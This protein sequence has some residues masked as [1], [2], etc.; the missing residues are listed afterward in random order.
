MP[1]VQKPVA[2]VLLALGAAAA[3]VT[4]RRRK[5][6]QREPEWQPSPAA[7]QPPVPSPTTARIARAR[8]AVPGPEVR[9]EESAETPETRY[10]RLGERESEE[11]RAAAERVLADPLNA[12][13]EREKSS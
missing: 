3:V 1:D 2:L 13:I 6:Q 8:G 10:E 4:L 9:E 7:E 5:A 11:R 12:T